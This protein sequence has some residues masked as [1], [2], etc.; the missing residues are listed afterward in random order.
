MNESLCLIRKTHYKGQKLKTKK[1]M[2]IIHN[3][4]CLKF[5]ILKEF[6]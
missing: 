3:I 4:F 6:N 1:L 2:K 5:L